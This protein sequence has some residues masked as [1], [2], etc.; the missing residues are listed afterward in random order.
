MSQNRSLRWMGMVTDSFSRDLTPSC[1]YG[2]R[3]GQNEQ[4][5]NIQS[6]SLSSSTFDV[7]LLLPADG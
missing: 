4:E 1:A 6:L 2:N 7:K 3:E 5:E